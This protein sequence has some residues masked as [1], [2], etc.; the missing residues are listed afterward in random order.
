MS[1]L[2][3]S[4]LIASVGAQIDVLT[5]HFAFNGYNALAAY[6][7][8]PLATA[9]ILYITLYGMGLTFGTMKGSFEELSKSAIKIGL[10]Y[11]FAMNWGYFSQYIVALFETAASELG[12]II[13]QSNPMQGAITGTDVNGALQQVLNQVV[14][15]GHTIEGQGALRH[16]LPYL[17][18]LLDW[19]FG[20]AIITLC[21]IELVTAKVMLAILFCVAPLFIIFALFSQTKSFFEK[22]LGALAGFAF[23]LVLVSAATAFAMSLMSWSMGLLGGEVGVGWIPLAFTA[24]LSFHA[25]LQIT[26]IAK[27][28]GGA[29]STSHGAVMMSAFVGGALGAAFSPF[30]ALNRWLNGWHQNRQDKKDKEKDREAFSQSI[31]KNISQELKRGNFQ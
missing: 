5:A 25:V 21:F 28:I 6:L 15:L 29:C 14:Q 22:W 23:V 20:G 31:A 13:L 18:A 9:C 26:H 3:Y 4:N 16:P 7:M 27:S 8:A 17:I 12:A 11:M 10:I 19:G 30:K 24:I 2:T 1:E